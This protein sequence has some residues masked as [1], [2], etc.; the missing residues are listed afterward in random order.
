MKIL[1]LL[2]LFIPFLLPSAY[3]D[4]MTPDTGTFRMD[5]N[6]E[7]PQKK[8]NSARQLEMQKEEAVEYDSFG[9]DEY[10]NNVDPD[11]Y[12]LDE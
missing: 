3:A 6:Y 8:L 5:D 12:E 7:K 9:E 2:A 1:R 4:D 10:N 11:A